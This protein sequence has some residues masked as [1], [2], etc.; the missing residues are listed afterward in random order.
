TLGSFLAYSVNFVVNPLIFALKTSTFG[1]RLYCFFNERWFF[2]KV[3]DNFLARSFLRFGNEVS[4]KALD[5]GAIEI[6]GPYGIS[7]F[8]YHY[9]FVMLLGLMIF[10]SVN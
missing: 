4:F 10:I 7:G 9:A 6:L 8:V 5:K 1:N 3:F 2:D